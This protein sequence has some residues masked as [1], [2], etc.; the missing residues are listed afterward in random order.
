MC[1]YEI[2]KNEV[3]RY[4]GYNGQEI[5]EDLKNLIEDCRNETRAISN[6]KYIYEYFD[7]EHTSQGIK[8]VNSD[9][10]FIS[11]DIKNHLKDCHSIVIMAVTAGANIEKN[12]KLMEK[13]NLTKALIMDA[14]ATTLV[15]E[16]CDEIE[17]AI[18]IQAESKKLNITSRFS[19]GYGDLS[20]EAQKDI[21]SLI[22]SNRRIGLNLSSNNILFP[23][24][25]VTAIIGIGKIEK[26]NNIN[27]CINCNKKDTCLFRRKG[28]SCGS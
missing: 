7:I 3:L 26:K 9:T 25:S 22:N 17:K 23:R 11:N 10:T 21:V 12:I 15:E 20:L 8:V 1:Y 28:K 18:K 2:N 5:Q 6:T 14:C 4:L 13:T 16:V 24:K 27:K 19:P